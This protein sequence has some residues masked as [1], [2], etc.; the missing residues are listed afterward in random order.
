[1]S[2]KKK[3][4]REAFRQAVFARDKNTC[5]MCGTTHA[6][7]D[8]HHI[9]DRNDPDLPNQGYV[10]E[11]GITLCD[12]GKYSCH[13]KAEAFHNELKPEPGF[14]PNELLKLIGSSRIEAIAAAGKLK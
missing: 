5:R 8:A 13:M 4:T 7:L 6:K 2:I 9:I 1:M 3:Q 12:D 11:N 14:S 10:V